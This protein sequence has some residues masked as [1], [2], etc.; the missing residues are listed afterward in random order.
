MS[1]IRKNNGFGVFSD[2]W[3]GIESD[4]AKAVGYDVDSTVPSVNVLETE[5][6]YRLE[7]AAPG[8]E[9]KDFEITLDQDILTV[10]V[11]KEKKEEKQ[12]EKFIRKE[13]AFHSFERSFKLPDLIDKEHITASYDQGVL[14]VEVPRQKQEKAVKTIKI[15]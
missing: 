1:L 3:N 12:S 5:K 11:G 2:L 4:L 10:S 14:K 15:V 13:F 7:F 8:L 9:K 6:G